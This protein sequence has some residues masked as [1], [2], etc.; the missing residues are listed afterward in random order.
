MIKEDGSL[1]LKK[2]VLPNNI[3]ISIATVPYLAN[4][5]VEKYGT[6]QQSAPPPASEI[7]TSPEGSVSD[8]ADF[9]G[10]PDMGLPVY[11]R[12]VSCVS[13][14]TGGKNNPSYVGDGRGDGVGH[15]PLY[16]FVNPK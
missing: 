2:R 14:K 12:A 1:L 4:K 10:Y 6:P 15:K 7:V 9:L 5:V 16:M 13:V 8:V 11:S 3:F